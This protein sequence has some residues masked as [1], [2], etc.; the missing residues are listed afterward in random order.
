M[1]LFRTAAG[2]A[3]GRGI[4]LSVDQMSVFNYA[5]YQNHVSPVR[6]IS[7]L[8]ETGIPA[9]GLALHILSDVH[10]F[11]E[12]TVPLP[13]VPAG[14]PVNVSDPVLMIDGKMLAGLTEEIVTAVT[15]ELLKDGESICGCREEMRVLAYDQWQGGS[16]FQSLLA[17]FVLPNHPV[18]AVLMHD[19]AERL[20]VWGLSP[21]LDGYQK[22]DPHRVRQ[23]AAAAYA[24]I[25]KKNIV[26]AEPPASF[27]AAGQRIRTPETVMEQRL[28]TCMDLTLLYAACLESLG[29]HPLLVMMD[30]HI[31]AG[32]WLRER[33]AEELKSHS[34]VIESVRELRM[35]CDNGS[36]ELTFVECTSFC[37][38]KEVDFEDSERMAK[39]MLAEA[40]MF[41]YA[42]DVA[43]ARNSG[44]RPLAFRIRNGG[45]YVIP[46]EDKA[47]EHITSAPARLDITAADL[48]AVTPKKVTGK[49]ELWESRLLDLTLRNMLLNLSRRASVVPLLSSHVDEL[50]DA[51][52]DG[53]EFQLMPVPEWLTS[54]TCTVPDENGN[55]EEVN[56]L[57]DTLTK[58]SIF[59]LTRW[60]SGADFDLNEKIRQE[61]KNHRLY[62]FS[63]PKQM[64]KDLTKVYRTA[65][66]SQL[67]NGVSSLYLA[68]GLMKWYPEEESAP[69]YAPLIL[70]PA[71][72]V[73]KPAA[74]G[75]GL[76]L[77]D[78]EAHFNSTL[79][80]MLRQ[81]FSLEI[82]GLDPLPT[83]EHGIDIRKVF[84]L[85]RSRLFSFKNWDVEE[86]CVIGNFS[87]AQFAIWNDIHTAEGLLESSRIVRSLLKGRIDWEN[88]LPEEDEEES[89]TLPVAADATQLEAIR[90]AVR[91]TTFVL[92]G[93]PG[94]GK[95]QTIT[96]MIASL[97]ERGKRVLF[98][99]EKMAALSVVQRRLTS[100]GIGDF[101]LEL[102]SDKANK[103][104]VLQQLARALEAQAPAEQP[105]YEEAL[106]SLGWSRSR[107]DEYVR[108]LHTPQPCG[109][110]LRGMIDRYEKV[111]TQEKEIFFSGAAVRAFSEKEL[112]SHLPLIARL[113]AA[114]GVMGGVADNPRT[115]V[116]LDSYTAEV[117]GALREETEK[118]RGLLDTTRRSAVP[119]AQ[120]L[121]QS[122]PRRKEEFAALEK[123]A[124]L[125]EESAASPDI[126]RTVLKSSRE[127]ILSYYRR[128]KEVKTEEQGLLALWKPEFLNLEMEWFLEK[129]GKA[130][131]KFFGKRGAMDAVTAEV[132]QYALRPLTFQ[133]IPG[134]LQAVT[135]HRRNRAELQAAFDQLPENEK[136]TVRQ[137]SGEEDYSVVYSAAADLRKREE[138]FP[139]GPEMIRLLAGDASAAGLFRE[140]RENCSALLETEQRLNSLLKRT[141][142]EGG[143]NWI[144]EE[145]EFCDL[146][147]RNPGALKDLGLYNQ[148][149]QEC[150]AAGLL[151]VVEAYEDGMEAEQLPDAYRKGVYSALISETIS[152]DDVL[153]SFSGASFEEAVRQFRTMDDAVM[154]K[155]RAEILRKLV[156]RVPTPWTSPEAGLELTLLRKAIG[157]SAR[158]M[159]IRKLFDRIPHILPALCPCMLMSPNSVA[160]YLAQQNDLFDIVVFDEASQLP[161]CK[162]AGALYRAKNAVIVGD[163]KQMPPTTFFAGSGPEVEDLQLDD[164]DSVLDDALALGVPSLYLKWHYRSTHESLIAFSNSRFYENRMFTFPSANDRERRVKTVRVEGVYRNGTNPKE[165]EAVVQ[166]ILRRYLDPELRTQSIGVV[167]FNVK[168]QALIENLLMRQYQRDPELDLWANS[169]EDPLF[170]KNLENVQGDER[171]AILFSITYG[172]DERGRISMNFGPV[173][174]EGGSKRL[175]VAFSRSRISMTVFASMGP[176]DMKVTDSSPEGVIAFRDFL[177]YAAGG[178]LGARFAAKTGADGDDGIL[179][180]ICSFIEQNGFR[181]ETMVGHSDFRLDI[182]VIDPYDP[183]EYMMGILLDGESYRRT[184]NTR[185]REVS[186][187]G[188]LRNLG[189]SLYRIWTV[190]WWDNRERELRKL[191]KELDR[192][193]EISQNRAEER[194]AKQERERAATEERQAEAQRRNEE[195]K[196]ELEAAEA[197]VIAEA[198]TEMYN[199]SSITAP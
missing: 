52:A 164:L 144:E 154:Q 50:E 41:K 96:G 18:I 110:S 56:W 59:E 126:Y 46:G 84:S 47:E 141:G 178:S 39:Q 103:K 169:G 22:K 194:K 136:S 29:L 63:T 34:M 105:E 176:E 76:H 97:L 32:V 140:F 14:K 122:T 12:C 87:F 99:A 137:L 98:V 36:D 188:V 62:T 67:E 163:P 177:S 69:C 51:L 111:R 66:T 183:E 45:E 184:S 107:L 199:V 19:T 91:G 191:L 116:K 180:S 135:A 112:H 37:A 94:T 108:H 170:V 198:E 2:D 104:H 168:Q 75:Y 181:C 171:D 134:L 33:S 23:L 139:G 7:V 121:G 187:A 90:T 106:R 78:E 172:P 161:T 26:Y 130:S 5:L 100:L 156:S 114:G 20:A 54:V 48:S 151:P 120:L 142:S 73:R 86:T 155:T 61:Y 27:T 16:T 173:N 148:V 138:R 11:A 31:F 13:A 166:E 77:R 9:E 160:Q 55:E 127:T 131:Q 128:E 70:L 30:G 189:W 174:Q 167:T 133:E 165:A 81:N 65:R 145:R 159:S 158:G 153:S 157:S 49:R 53:Q 102:H 149:R 42:V 80:E 6:G 115:G 152:R 185:D 93:P 196:S 3:A 118:Y 132:G 64:E 123:T 125:F 82:G 101:C 124:E 28:G 119:A 92:H 25:Q 182:A 85:V 129:H 15:V 89:L 147:L 68:V 58:R 88:E 186:Q 193:K 146:L 143:R 4:S 83:D 195:L 57:G 113:T 74:Q 38:G 95:S 71:E 150:A 40:D 21:S 60:P 175:N 192:Q 109:L 10:F 197:E 190:D 35:R 179:K 1:D 24:A 43:C 79:L 162:A 17:S 8:N 44:I 72:M 117:R